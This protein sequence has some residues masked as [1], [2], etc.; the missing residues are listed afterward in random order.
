LLRILP[1]LVAAVLMYSDALWNW[2]RIVYDWGQRLGGREPLAEIIII[3]IDQQSIDAIGRWPWPR[4]VH[5]DLVDRLS[6]G[7]PDGR[8]VLAV[9]LDIVF[10]EP[11]TPRADNRLIEAVRNHGR[12]VL[13]VVNEQHRQ[14]GQLREILPV[15]GLT[16]HA[17]AL[18]HID[19]PI[20]A[21][22]ISRSVYLKAGLGNPHWP[23]FG[24][25]MLQ[26][27]YPDLLTELPGVRLETG[28]N[29]SPYVWRRDNHIWLSYTG[30][31]GH[32][33]RVSYRDV[34]DNAVPAD[35]FAGKLV[36]VGATAAGLGDRLPTP[37][38]GNRKPMPGVEI[39]AN[40]IDTLAN[41]LGI[42]PLPLSAG[43][44]LTALLVLISTQLLSRLPPRWS[45]ITTAAI[46]LTAMLM[47]WL[48][49]RFLHQ[50]F[51][52]MAAIVGIIGGYIL[53]SWLRLVHTIQ[54][55][56]RSLEK[57]ENEPTVLDP[58][59]PP[60]LD[61][62]MQFVSAMLPVES[63]QLQDR[64][65][66]VTANWQGSRPNRSGDG[67]TIKYLFETSSVRLS[68]SWTGSKPLNPAERALLTDLAGK[69][70]H[71]EIYRPRTPVEIL[72][73][74]IQQ[75]EFAEERLQKMRQ[76]I[77]HVL[78]Q[79]DEG[80][81]VADNFGN[82]LLANLPAHAMLAEKDESAM[83]GMPL[84]HFWD[85]LNFK[86]VSKAL[87]ALR[88]AVVE[89]TPSE[90]EATGPENRDLLVKLVPFHYGPAADGI[91]IDIVDITL[92][93]DNERQ[94][95]D[96][97][98]FLSHDLRSPLAS[99]LAV[100]Q[101]VE[102]QPD[103]PIEPRHIKK[104]AENAR[105][106]LDL[107]DDFLNLL[108]V[109][110][111]TTETF[112]R[113]DLVAA[114][115]RSISTLSDLAISRNITLGGDLDQPVFVNGDAG[116]LERMITNLL[117]NAIKYSP[118]GSTVTAG[119]SRRAQEIH[120][121]VQDTGY[122]IEPAHIPMLFERFERIPRKEHQQEPGSGLGLLFVKSVVALHQGTIE[123]ESEVN[124]GS[125]FTI[126]L[127]APAI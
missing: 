125:R 29:E 39:I 80:I 119:V 42:T 9:G 63:A 21:D 13:P 74:R 115:S 62:V 93:K 35:Q 47:A 101:L 79:M 58:Q 77:L 22:S 86:S 123:V 87:Q 51:A 26:L 91:I 1:V 19:R 24:L 64:D 44:L 85:R 15:P 88:A 127:P 82:I 78:E 71:S 16:E 55:L 76:F 32:F 98:S 5:A 103:H 46:A 89:R 60:V 45:L 8:G 30:P 105:R 17:A 106:T 70:S 121:W 33:P 11:S 69:F 113:V 37:V 107:A 65:G 122:G 92:L 118:D 36:L 57:L 99:I 73:R 49:L 96:V 14:G 31:P 112:T 126:T 66:T 120:C 2:D 102:M 114:A 59:D 109:E 6:H 124:K 72:E 54:H 61:A 104:I 38:S 90:A 40:E 48:G 4:S 68:V 12:V 83:Q 41:N 67:E 18:G 28:V 117:S 81:V 50:W 108:F 94:R 84:H 43:L 34:L 111:I 97:L 3:E 10:S 7:K 52:P 25:A 27:A 100:T 23:S 110:N 56:N 20:D 53:W 116:L 75:V 95:R